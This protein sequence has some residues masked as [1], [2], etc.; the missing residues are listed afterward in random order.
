MPKIGQKRHFLERI[1]RPSFQ[2]FYG[3]LVANLGAFRGPNR[4]EIARSEPSFRTKMFWTEKCLS[5]NPPH[6]GAISRRAVSNGILMLFLR[7][8]IPKITKKGPKSD[9]RKTGGAINA[10]FILRQLEAI[11]Q[12]V[13]VHGIDPEQGPGRVRRFSSVFSCV[14]TCHF[15]LFESYERE[16]RLS[17]RKFEFPTAHHVFSSL[18]R[19][20]MCNSFDITTFISDKKGRVI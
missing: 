10:P 8:E 15:A 3:Y 18:W 17:S 4:G 9:P 5:R 19:R 16:R 11:Y 7:T 20:S 14:T 6:L 12:I 1:R 13:T 2:Y